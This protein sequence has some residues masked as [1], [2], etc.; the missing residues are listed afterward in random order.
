MLSCG[1]R[2]LAMSA[3]DVGLGFCHKVHSMQ[4]AAVASAYHAKHVPSL[5]FMTPACL[6]PGLGTCEDW[7]SG[8]GHKTSWRDSVKYVNLASLKDLI[9]LFKG[10]Y[11]ALYKALCRA[12]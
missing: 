1:R 6:P 3:P 2:S 4:L 10:P 8:A 9:R 11:K 12:L 7:C 5:A